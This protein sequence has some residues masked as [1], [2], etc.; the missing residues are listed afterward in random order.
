MRHQ[1]QKFTLG[2]EASVRKALMRSLTES[3]ILHDGIVT[4]LA[5]AKALRTVVEPLVTQAKQGSLAARRNSKRFLYTKAAIIRLHN[6]VAPRYKDRA[7]GYTRIIK[8]GHRVNDKGD[9]ARIEFV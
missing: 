6:T 8:L 2:R 1:K 3:L 9:M 5:K 7:G 4:T